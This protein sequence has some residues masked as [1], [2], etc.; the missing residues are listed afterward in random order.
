MIVSVS[1]LSPA[2]CGRAGC[3]VASS[4]TYALLS[5][6]TMTVMVRRYGVSAR[7]LLLI[8]PDELGEYSAR[9]WRW[10]RGRAGTDG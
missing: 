2:G 3:A 1:P 9:A 5:A 8:R 6:T 7:D 4:I 10:L